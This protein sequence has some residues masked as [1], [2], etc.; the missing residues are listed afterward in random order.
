MNLPYEARI[1]VSWHADGNLADAIEQHAERI[2]AE[3]LARAFNRG[4]IESSSEH[5]TEIEGAHLGLSITP[6]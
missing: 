6:A 1:D 5:D 4:G 2:A 3:T